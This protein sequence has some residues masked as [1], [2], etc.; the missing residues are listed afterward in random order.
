MAQKVFIVGGG[1][2]VGASTAYALA[3]QQVVEEIILIDIDEQAAWGQAAD[4]NDAMA[5]SDGV[6]VR[7][8]D[9]K[10][11]TDN[12]IVVVTS[13]A[14]QKPS[15]SRL[16]LLGTNAGI[17]RSV[18]G[19]VMEHCRNPFIILVA[20]PVDVLTYVALKVSGLPKNRVFG[21]GTTLDSFRLCV[22]LANALDVADNEVEAYVLGEHGDSSFAA[23]SS[24]RIGDIPLTSYP[25]FSHAMV[26]NIDNDIRQRV[27]KII[28][29]K[30]S[31]Y[32]AIG[33]VVAYII[34]AMQRDAAKILPLCT[35]IEGEYGLNDVVI[36]LPCSLDINGATTVPGYQLS[37]TEQRTLAYSAEVIKKAISSLDPAIL[38][39]IV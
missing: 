28:E 23:V 9:Y 26:A 29:A 25:G 35:F 32:F 1:G 3:L 8:G 39:S 36:G 31:T 12:D 15:Q 37:E 24:A 4:I 21:T 30:H 22:E 20:N 18:I 14:P 6:S 34:K 11:I 27:Y 5:F 10:E 2:M 17:I 33:E 13:G 38:T 7:A 16:D 19:N